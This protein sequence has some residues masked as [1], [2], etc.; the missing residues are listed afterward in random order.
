MDL[1][2]AI[3][4]AESM[5]HNHMELEEDAAPVVVAGGSAAVVALVPSGRRFTAHWGAE[6]AEHLV[7]AL[8]D[9]VRVAGHGEAPIYIEWVPDPFVPALQAIGFEEY[10]HWRDFWIRDLDQA[11]A[12]GPWQKGVREARPEDFAAA[13]AVTQECR[14]QSR[15]FEGEDEAFFH[16][17]V[18]LSP[19]VVLVAEQDRRVVGTACLRIYGFESEK[20][21]VCWLRELAVSPAFQDR[22]IGQAL[23]M[24]GLEWGKTGGARRSFLATDRLNERAIGLYT[25]IGY[26]LNEVDPGQRNMIG[27]IHAR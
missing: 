16:E 27:T 19:S 10:S 11:P 25:R 13:A 12:G 5:P 22:G 6:R 21:P 23:V 17:W 24:A 1:A 18:A 8:R 15:G 7:S 26:R 20:G 9:A 4:L 14:F 2:R 3:H